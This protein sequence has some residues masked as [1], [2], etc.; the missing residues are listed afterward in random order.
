MGRIGIPTLS[1]F[2]YYLESQLK[3]GNEIGDTKIRAFSVITGDISGYLFLFSS[4]V[5]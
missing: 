5:W 1:N 3:I 2:L 4:G